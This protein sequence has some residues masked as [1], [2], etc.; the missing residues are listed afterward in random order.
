MSLSFSPKAE[1]QVYH[2]NGGAG[3]FVEPNKMILLR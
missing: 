1:Q 3:N 2:A